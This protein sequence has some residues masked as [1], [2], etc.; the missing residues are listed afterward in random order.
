MN[1]TAQQANEVPRIN[2]VSEAFQRQRAAFVKDPYVS[3]EQRRNHL[4]TLE[5]LL[6]DN[7]DAICEAI[8]QDFGN[9]S[10]HETKMLEL[11][12]SIDGLKDARRQLKKWMKP[13]RRHVSMWFAGAKN[14]VLPQ[15]KG[16]VGVVVPWNYPLFL[17]IGPLTSALAAGN[18]CMV[19]MAANSQ[20]LCRLLAKLVSEKFDPQT[21]VILPGVS[22]SEFTDQPYDHIIFTG[23][24]EVG[25]NVMQKASQFLT[26][27]TLELG[28]KSPAIICD[29]FDIATA[30]QRLVQAKL[31]NAGQT[32]VAPDYLFVPADKIDE[33]VRQAQ[34]VAR[35]R[36]A[37]LNTKDFTSII[38]QR[39]YDR[40]MQTLSDAESKGARRIP[41]LDSSEPLENQHKIPPTLLLDVND[42]MTVMQ[43]EI[44]G[45]LLPVKPYNG[46]D[47][48]LHFINER[49]NP[50]ALYLFTDKKTVQDRVLKR[51]LS[52]GVCLNDCMFHVAQ[53]DMPFGGIGNSGIGHYH[54]YEGFL[55]FSKLRPVFK[56]AKIPGTAFLAPPYGKVFNFLY[57]FM[58]R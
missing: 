22:A 26:P 44:F 50:L 29:D 34:S 54:G 56:Q 47:E 28:G 7:Q 4:S 36:Y 13:Q 48:V 46:L 20:H 39:A 42:D 35:K 31:Y 1:V 38:D 49:E 3:L 15:P 51:T 17:C 30:A 12:G 43:E 14:T 19:K 25:K 23:S 33:F 55:E 16:V 5:Q 8:N 9:R 11:F 40:L 37:D 57:K 52:G 58:T 53:H 2:Q 10:M 18:R 27:V 45:P 41:L 6:R 32:C 21:L 24:P